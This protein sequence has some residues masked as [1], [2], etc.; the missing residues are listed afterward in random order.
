MVQ[1]VL[2][3]QPRPTK[4][5]RTGPVERL[6]HRRAPRVQAKMHESGGR[7]VRPTERHRAGRRANHRRATGGGV[8]DVIAAV[9]KK[10]P[11]PGN[12]QPVRPDT[13]SGASGLDA[14]AEFDPDAAEKLQ[15][16]IDREKRA[17]GA[18]LDLPPIMD[19]A[20]V[21]AE[22][23]SRRKELHNQYQRKERPDPWPIIERQFPRIALTIRRDWGKRALDDYFAT[24]VVDDRGSRQG[25]PP[26]VLTAI[27]E[28]A[29][30]HAEHYRF[31]KP[32]R[33]WEEDVSQTKWWDR[34]T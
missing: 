20:A 31:A 33:P 24:L 7:N 10:P 32:F 3:H 34:G 13:P 28:V 4:P 18:P 27:L 1:D 22:A 14:F 25:F 26:D 17:N 6:P 2:V 29:R 19:D 15:R 9:E 21:E 23:A 8:S 30:L 16:R 12:E 5:A 11:M